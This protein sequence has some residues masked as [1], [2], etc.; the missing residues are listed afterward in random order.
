MRSPVDLSPVHWSNW[1]PQKIH[2]FI[3]KAILD[4]IPYKML[5]N[6]RGVY[7][8][9]EKCPLCFA[10]KETTY[11]T[12]MS[13]HFAASIWKRIFIIGVGEGAYFYQLGNM[14]ISI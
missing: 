6:V 5:L 4:R 2:G 10:Y 1:E 8:G 7:I 12:L 14:L 3:W 9:S 13:F 11:H